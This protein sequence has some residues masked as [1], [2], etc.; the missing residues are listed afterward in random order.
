MDWNSWKT[1]DFKEFHVSARFFFS[2]FHEKY[3]GHEITNEVDIEYQTYKITK[4]QKIMAENCVPDSWQVTCWTGCVS[5]VSFVGLFAAVGLLKQIHTN[6]VNKQLVS[7]SW[8]WCNMCPPNCCS[9]FAFNQQIS[10]PHKA[11]RR[12]LLW[13][14]MKLILFLQAR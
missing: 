14:L 5:L 4:F 11:G 9:I 6:M 13:N 12:I 10:V 7:H 8:C 2:Q 1:T 3:H